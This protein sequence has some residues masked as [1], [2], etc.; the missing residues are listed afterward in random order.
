MDTFKTADKIG[1]VRSHAAKELKLSFPIGK[2][3]SEHFL[4]GDLD[5]NCLYEFSDPLV[6]I[7]YPGLIKNPEKALDTLGGIRL[8]ENA[9]YHRQPLQKEKL[10]LK[11]HPNNVYMF[12]CHSDCH[13]EL[14]FLV[15]I[16]ENLRTKDISYEI[17]GAT[18]LAFK[19]ERMCDFQYLPI[20]E[21]EPSENGEVSEF[22]YNKIF[23]N[24]LPTLEWML[25]NDSPLFLVPGRY[26]RFDQPQNL[27]QA[28]TTDL[29]NNIIRN[30]GRTTE[31][32]SQAQQ[33]KQKES[34]VIQVNFG[35][36]VE[37]PQNSAPNVFD[38]IAAKS[39]QVPYERVKKLF[40]ERPIWS[41][42][43]IIH[44]LGITLESAKH[45][46]PC[47]A[48]YCNQ[49]PW[50]T[51]WIKFGYNPTTDFNS[52]IYQVLDCRIGLAE[53]AQLKIRTKKGTSRVLA[54]EK[55]VSLTTPQESYF[56]FKPN[57]IPPARQMFYM[58]CDIHVPEIQEMFR[59][60]PKLP[61][62]AK[63]SPMSG[64]LPLKF[65]EQCREIVS[66][67]IFKAVHEE[68]L[69]EKRHQ[70]EQKADKSNVATYCSQMLSNIRRGVS[71][72]VGEYSGSQEN[73]EEIHVSDSDEE[74]GEAQVV[75]SL[76]ERLPENSDDEDEIDQDDSDLDIDMEA[77]EEVNELVGYMFPG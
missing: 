73:L 26:A 1:Q 62:S 61:P 18:N 55:H 34:G 14:G 3:T 16:K 50:R 52:R 60:L 15:K 22:I 54:E 70:A 27:V 68:L 49:G 59:K 39:L 40:D 8:I 13:E 5:P 21:K 46:L 24:Q 33:K 43:A 30:S 69:K 57:V 63:C 10:T 32:K 71:Q 44:K 23:R 12:G 58:F 2:Q 28:G 25:K 74:I 65:H 45:I 51:A 53:G 72:S 56:V 75:K 11:F 38:V 19:F 4:G 35:D 37:V 47:L 29:F 64:W 41:K 42:V 77:V 36:N 17:L 6:R 76:P 66:K 48:Y 67:C 9:I 7:E 20:K 31:T